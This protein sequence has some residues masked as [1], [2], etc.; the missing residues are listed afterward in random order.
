[1]DGFSGRAIWFANEMSRQPTI[2]GLVSTIIPVYNRPKMLVQALESV[3]SQTYRPIEIIIADDGSTDET[4]DVANGLCEKHPEIVRYA[5]HENQG[6]GPT[7]EL[8]RQLAQGEFIQYLDSDDRLLPN[9]FADQVQALGNHPECDVAYGISRLVDQAGNVLAD[10]FKWT[11]Q[12]R[13]QLYPGLLVDRWWCTHTPLYRRS[14]TDRIGGWCDMRWSQDWEYDSRIGSIKTKVVTCGKH[15][16]EHCHHDGDRQTSSDQSKWE[17]DPT[18]LRNRVRLLSAL[19]NGAEKAGVDSNAPE[20]QHFAR[21]CF[22]I[23]RNC[24]AQKMSSEA[25]TLLTLADTAAGKHGE[26]RKGLQLYRFLL[27]TFGCTLTSIL[28]SLRQRNTTS[29]ATMQQSFADR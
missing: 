9:K 26:G 17:T 14:L 27:N 22:S 15:V 28:V 19:W 5:R 10:P 7:R 24:V 3:M 2:E 4:P 18:R 25:R 12:Q 1:M 13:D 16:S 20:R 11:D 29:S 21:W 6:P 8:G 23:A